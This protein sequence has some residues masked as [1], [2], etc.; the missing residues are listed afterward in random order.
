MQ[1]NPVYRQWQL[2]KS[3]R[4]ELV[5]QM[6]HFFTGFDGGIGAGAVLAGIISTFAGYE[7]MFALMAIFPF[8]AGILYYIDIRLKR[9]AEK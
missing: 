9:R 1:L 5:P 7:M 6:L 4:K 3:L 8:L 2:L